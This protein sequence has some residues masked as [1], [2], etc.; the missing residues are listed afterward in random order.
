[1]AE[2]PQVTDARVTKVCES[3]GRFRPYQPDDSFCVECGFETL[4]AE[5]T[6]GR[7][8]DYVMERPETHG[9]HCPRCGKDWR[10][11]KSDW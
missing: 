11:R 10:G 1:M 9:L 8:F 3:C 2:A 4:A 7:S 5:C 6:C